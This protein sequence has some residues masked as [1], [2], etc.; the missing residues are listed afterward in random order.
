MTTMVPG[1][2]P[3]PGQQGML[4]PMIGPALPTSGEPGWTVWSRRVW[5]IAPLASAPRRLLMIAMVAGLIGTAVW[6]PS[7]LSIGYLVV[8]TMVFAAVYG[9]AERRPTRTECAGIGLT[10]ALLAVPAVLAAEWLGVLCIVAAWIVGW[11]TLF[12]GRTWTAVF[13]GPFLPWGLPAR[14]GG[15]VRRGVPNRAGVANPGRIAV[16]IGLTVVLVV[17]FGALFASADAAFAHFVGNLVPAFDGGEAIARVVVFG[18]VASFVLG[19]AY[20][21]RFPPRLD[22]MAP[23]PMKPVPRWEWALPLGVLDALF[24]AFVVVQAAVLFGGHTHVL[25]TEGLTY[26]EYARQ[27]FW[28]LLWV[29][30]LTLLVLAVVIRVAGRADAGDRRVLRALV[31]V[32]CATSVVVVISAIHRMWLYQ[33][34]Y[35]F[36]TDRVMVVTIELWLGAVFLLVAATGI[37]MSGRWLPHAVLV[38]G[39]VALL[40]LAALNPER[41]VA[42]RNIDRFE[43]TGALDAEYLSGLSSDID[44]ALHRLPAHIRACVR[45]DGP[46]SDPWYEFNLSRSRA[47]RPVVTDLPEYCSEYWSYDYR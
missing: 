35:G 21:T 30:T 6:R 20:L 33:Q 32:L 36:S 27:G 2:P 47:D 29:S 23:S 19:G 40:G 44:P 3:Y 7:V 8:G 18:I 15:W 14:V 34:A 9:T 24:I 31:G 37:R 11:C 43:Q 42:D 39:V 26:A 4:P 22:A 41:L 25:E 45:S 12:G 16:V 5:P 46:D 38:A 1:L 17:V 28:Q 10:L 13:A